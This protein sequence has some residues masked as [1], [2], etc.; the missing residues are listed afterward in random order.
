[1][2]HSETTVTRTR[3]GARRSAKKTQAR[4]S[5]GLPTSVAHEVQRYA[6]TI[7]IS[8]NQAIGRFVRLGLESQ[9]KRKREFFD[10]LKKNLANDD[11]AQQDRLVDE[12][13]NLILGQ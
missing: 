9:E 1:M 8:M 3:R 13:R 4:Y 10:R 5:V 11:P 2:P 6:K 7:D 12:F